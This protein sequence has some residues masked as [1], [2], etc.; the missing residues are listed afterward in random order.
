MCSHMYTHSFLHGFKN[1][2]NVLHVHRHPCIHRS[3]PSNKPIWAHIM[4]THTY[5][6]QPTHMEKIANIIT[7][8]IYPLG[9]YVS[10]TSTCEWTR[11]C[12]TQSTYV[13][14]HECS[15]IHICIN[16][17]VCTQTVHCPCTHVRIIHECTLTHIPPAWLR[18]PLANIVNSTH[19][20][21]PKL[22]PCT[23]LASVC[24]CS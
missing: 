24:L 6:R 13:R 1:E 22:N 23:A 10:F 15:H 19:L 18:V 5:M 16:V 14:I 9:F 2:H 20:R 3:L 4:L 8:S 7:K 21:L 11:M 17:H 12:K